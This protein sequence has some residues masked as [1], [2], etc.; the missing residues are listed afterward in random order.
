MVKLVA[1]L[2]KIKVVNR[3]WWP[4]HTLYLYEGL[5]YYIVCDI[6]I[7]YKNYLQRCRNLAYKKINKAMTILPI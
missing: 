5:L 4:D 3:V 7:F 6:L 2:K 1:L